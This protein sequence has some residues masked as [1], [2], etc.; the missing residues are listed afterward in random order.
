MPKRMIVP[1][2]INPLVSF[3]Y[4]CGTNSCIFRNQKHLEEIVMICQLFKF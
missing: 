1:E 3:K 2:E 4:F